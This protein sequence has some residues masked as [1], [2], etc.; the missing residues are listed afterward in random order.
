LS[1]RTAEIHVTGVLNKLGPN[2][3]TQISRWMA[4]AGLAGDS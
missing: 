2:S 3:K 1:E 4:V